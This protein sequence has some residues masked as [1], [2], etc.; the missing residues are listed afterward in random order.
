MEKE[1]RTIN[2]ERLNEK[3]RY[4]MELLLKHPEMED[5]IEAMFAGAAGRG[6][7]YGEA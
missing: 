2:A 6:V 5:E 4:F 7:Q 3:T 1:I